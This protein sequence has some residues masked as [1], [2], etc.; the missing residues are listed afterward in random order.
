[1][2]YSFHFT[3]AT[4]DEAKAKAVAEFEGVVKSQP[5]HARDRD[6][7]LANINAALD[8]M[9]DDETKDI[10][11]ECYGSLMFKTYPDEVSGVTIHAGAWHTP[12]ETV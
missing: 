3:A 11:V 5:E 7:A 4:K 10:R 6:A 1:M 2:S 8:A 9:N 12:K